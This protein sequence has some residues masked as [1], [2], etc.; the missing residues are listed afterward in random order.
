MNIWS[1]HMG[2]SAP[3]S[4]S[5]TYMHEVLWEFP[6][7]FVLLYIDDILVYSPS[8]IEHCQHVVKV[9]SISPH[10]IFLD[11]TSANIVSRWTRR[12]WKR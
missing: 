4:Y 8:I 10:C 1:C 9:V 12:R 7:W 5:G 6:L 3:P 2:L 11:I